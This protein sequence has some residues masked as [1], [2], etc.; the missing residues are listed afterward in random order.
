MDFIER[1]AEVFQSQ[2]TLGYW[3]MNCAFKAVEGKNTQIQSM[4]VEDIN[5][6]DVACPGMSV[7]ALANKHAEYLATLNAGQVINKVN[8]QKE[9]RYHC[10]RT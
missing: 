7:A 4:I 9:V 6:K 5:N 10:G 1:A 8:A 3:W 2:V